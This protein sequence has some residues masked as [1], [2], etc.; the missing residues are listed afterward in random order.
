MLTE[1]ET[2]RSVQGKKY[3]E[4]GKR[5]KIKKT[6]SEKQNRPALP[7]LQY[8]TLKPHKEEYIHEGI[9]IRKR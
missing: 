1:K 9:S 2:G 4:K 5:E 3:K 8:F 6:G 7:L